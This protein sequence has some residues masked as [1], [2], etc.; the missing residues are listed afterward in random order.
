[1]VS[2]W[3][4]WDLLLLHLPLLVVFPRLCCPFNNHRQDPQT[5]G[6]H[7]PKNLRLTYMPDAPSNRL[8]QKIEVISEVHWSSTSTCLQYHGP[9]RLSSNSP[10]FLPKKVIALSHLVQ[11]SDSCSP[12]RWSS[13][14]QR[15]GLLSTVDEGPKECSAHPKN[16]LLQ[17]SI[18]KTAATSAQFPTDPT[19]DL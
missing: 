8:T 12:R 17:S 5:P 15:G 13:W 3:L 11:D 2:S 10:D 1:M 18:Q 4:K 6:H 7:D 9:S 19:S 16:H 14:W